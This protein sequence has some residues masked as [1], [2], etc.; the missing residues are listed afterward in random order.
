M[1]LLLPILLTLYVIL[2]DI[3]WH[4]PSGREGR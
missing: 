2:L 4:P 1:E 3:G